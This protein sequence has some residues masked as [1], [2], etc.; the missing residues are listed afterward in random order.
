MTVTELTDGVVLLR[1]HTEGDVPA[2]VEQCTDP[3]SLR[4]T[5]VPRPY[6]TGAAA[7]RNPAPAT[8]G[9]TTTCGTGCCCATTDRTDTL[10]RGQS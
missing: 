7:S 2:I 4:W 8:T 9:R 10:V 6:D 5:T 3:E 1:A